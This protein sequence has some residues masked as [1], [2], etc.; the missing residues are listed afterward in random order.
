MVL[1]NAHQNS[2]MAL[3]G[4]FVLSGAGLLAA[5]MQLVFFFLRHSKH[6]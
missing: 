3:L 6:L 4:V 5:E 2:K 1:H